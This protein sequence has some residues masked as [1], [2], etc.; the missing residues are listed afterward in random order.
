MRHA[1]ACFLVCSL[2]CLFAASCG[3]PPAATTQPSAA[4]Q[5]QNDIPYALIEQCIKEIEPYAYTHKQLARFSTSHPPVASRQVVGIRIIYHAPR[6]FIA[7]IP[8]K[9]GDSRLKFI[10]RTADLMLVVK[11][12]QETKTV[13]G[14]TT[15]TAAGY[16]K[17]IENPEQKAIYYLKKTQNDAHVP[18]TNEQ[19]S[20]I[21][22]KKAR[23]LKAPDIAGITVPVD[24]GKA[25]GSDLPGTI[26]LAP[27]TIK[28]L[29]KNSPIRKKV[30]AAV[31]DIEAYLKKQRMQIF[32][33]A[34]G[35]D[36]AFARDR[37]APLASRWG[38]YNERYSL[39][40]FDANGL[41]D[42][43]VDY[44]FGSGMVRPSTTV[45]LEHIW[46]L[47]AFRINGALLKENGKWRVRH[48]LS[49]YKM[50]TAAGA[51]PAAAELTFSHGTI[52]V[53]WAPGTKPAAK[54][55]AVREIKWTPDKQ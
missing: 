47:R 4:G 20:A 18:L 27:E 37:H 16:A 1:R 11:F 2:G 42:L 52:T 55:E 33:T 50:K 45:I 49:R 41:A 44:Q 22:G 40:D 8:P 46:L 13:L 28:Q 31:K 38:G 36:Y 30:Q 24:A 54:W 39:D 35:A 21:L 15:K 26:A 5:A 10:D 32:R 14:V 6:A 43:R 19:A 29:P 23:E 17:T 7:S 48:P 12:R 53:R 51:E 3:A 34:N 25:S 9:P